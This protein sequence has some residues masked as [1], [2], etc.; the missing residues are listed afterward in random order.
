MQK[1]GLLRPLDALFGGTQ[2]RLMSLLFCNP[3]QSFAITELIELARTGSGVSQRILGRLVAAELV[4]TSYQGRRR[5]YHANREA[6]LFPELRGL[7]IKTVGLVGPIREALQPLA[8]KIELALIFG[9]IAKG[10]ERAKSDVDLLVVTE[11]LHL[12]EI[13]AALEPVEAQIGRPIS[14]TVYRPGEYNE[15]L[16]AKNPFLTKVLAGDTLELIGHVDAK[17][18][19]R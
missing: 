1:H 5:V 10:S 9:S 6:P 17:R 3:D 4:T 19:T 7:F 11:E 8:S 2:Q 13:F 15:R 14:P 12:D 18:A 16:R